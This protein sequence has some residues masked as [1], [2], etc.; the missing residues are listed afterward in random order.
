MSTPGGHNPHE[1][2]PNP[3]HLEDKHEEGWLVSYADMMTLLFG[4]F[5]ILFSM[6]N[7]DKKKY[8]QL[9]ESLAKEF[10][11]QKAV[12]PPPPPPS[13]QLNKI[14]KEQLL[15]SGLNLKEVEIKEDKDGL[16]ISMR[17][18]AFFE[19]GQTSL[20]PEGSAFVH[21]VG[22]AL[23]ASHLPFEARV[24]GHTDDAPIA[25]PSFP[26]NWEL[27]AARA[28]GVVRKMAEI[29]LPS[30]N[31][32]AMGYGDSRPLVANRMPDGTPIAENMSKNR[33]VVVYIAFPEQRLPASKPVAPPEAANTPAAPANPAAPAA[34]PAHA[35]PVAPTQAAPESVH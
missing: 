1:H 2:R 3:P 9:S 7:M 10:K 13:A 17:G 27:S 22:K 33:R 34:E 8:E 21:E 5:V 23:I 20:L 24:E 31:L 15:K 11:E 16:S 19:S 14:L 35:E 30:R 29:G 32:V 12:P 4:F 6:S 18:S 28:A 26:T 25:S